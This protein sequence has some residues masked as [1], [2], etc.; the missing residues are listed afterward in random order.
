MN[1]HHVDSELY[2]L[3]DGSGDL[4]RYI[5]KLAVEKDSGA[6]RLEPLDD[7]GTRRGE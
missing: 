4:R 1:R 6:L 2:R 3:T 7:A 5:V